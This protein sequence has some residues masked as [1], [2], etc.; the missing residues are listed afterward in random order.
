MANSSVETLARGTSND[1]RRIADEVARIEPEFEGAVNVTVTRDPKFKV[2]LETLNVRFKFAVLARTRSH[3]GSLS[4]I[5][6]RSFSTTANEMR[7]I[8]TSRDL[9][10]PIGYSAVLNR[11]YSMLLVSA[12][13]PKRAVGSNGPA[14]VGVSHGLTLS[15]S[16]RARRNRRELKWVCPHLE[17]ILF[18]DG[19]EKR[20]GGGAHHNISRHVCQYLMRN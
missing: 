4:F 15:L 5:P 10:L 2:I 12:R 1:L 11:W 20:F 18:G 3:V 14:T 16:P 19:I 6:C 8:V 13:H 9:P 17:P 7:S